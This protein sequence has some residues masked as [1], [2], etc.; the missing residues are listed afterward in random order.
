MNGRGFAAMTTFQIFSHNLYNT[1]IGQNRKTKR[2]FIAEQ[3]WQWGD[4]HHYDNNLHKLCQLLCEVSLLDHCALNTS[5]AAKGIQ[6][7]SGDLTRLS[8][9]DLTRVNLNNR[10]DLGSCSGKEELVRHP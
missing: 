7:F 1:D 10:D 2:K 8:V 6:E 5:A 9:A 4:P 3:S